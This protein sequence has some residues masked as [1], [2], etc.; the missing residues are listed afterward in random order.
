MRL[1]L[2][3]NVVLFAIMNDRRL[4]PEIRRLISE[5]GFERHVSV[6][7][8]WEVALKS[9]IGKL[10]I[11]ASRVLAVLEATRLSLLNLEASH[12]LTMESL[13]T[14]PLHRDPFDR[15][16]LAQARAEGLTFVTADSHLADYGV[17]ILAA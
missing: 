5:E 2:D 15:M 1:L 17:P 12:V 7:S 13:P 11:E 14:L 10:Q 6:V 8:L 3:T 16:L 4:T 9:A